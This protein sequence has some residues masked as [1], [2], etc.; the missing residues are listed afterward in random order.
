ML[1]NNVLKIN[2]QFNSK[3]KCFEYFKQFISDET[4]NMLSD[5]Q[6]D[7]PLNAI[8]NLSNI[9]NCIWINI[10]ETTNKCKNEFK[11]NKNIWITHYK[12]NGLFLEFDEIKRLYQKFSFLFIKDK[13]TFYF[14]GLYE[15][16]E[17]EFSESG[18]VAT[19]KKCNINSIYLNELNISNFFKENVQKDDE[20][21]NKNH[22]VYDDKISALKMLKEDF[23]NINFV[24]DNLRCDTEII[25]AYWKSLEKELKNEN[26]FH[27]LKTCSI[28]SVDDFGNKII[29]EFLESQKTKLSKEIIK[30]YNNLYTPIRFSK[31]VKHIDYISNYP[32][33][34]IDFDIEPFSK[35]LCQLIILIGEKENDFARNIK[36]KYQNTE[37]KQLDSSICFLEIYTQSLKNDNCKLITKNTN[38][39]FSLLQL[40][41]YAPGSL[42]DGL[43][44]MTYLINDTIRN[45]ELRLYKFQG[46][47]NNIIDQIE[48]SLKENTNDIFFIQLIC[49]KKYDPYIRLQII[50][51]IINTLETSSQI[52][53]S[54]YTCNI[55]ELEL[56]ILTC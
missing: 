42:F 29:T 30:Q 18:T 8:S 26:F 44:Y 54:D 15:L 49:N 5:S 38:E 23:M 31:I 2:Q 46:K 51:E 19:Y 4:F 33:T 9:K 1:K 20:E 55:E 24:S 39:I 22:T 50:N 40:I 52:P 45:K 13:D 32:V 17:K 34:I 36:M 41:F 12:C 14:L 21:N 11:N 3:K 35:F 6:N 48:K 7:V 10:V 25:N 16:K 43:T 47:I 37:N 53:Y 28:I 56:V 27:F